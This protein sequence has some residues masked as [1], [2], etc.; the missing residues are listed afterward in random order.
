MNRKI[1]GIAVIAVVIVGGVFGVRGLFQSKTLKSVNELSETH[2]GGA[3]LKEVARDKSDNIYSSS[4]ITKIEG[5]GKFNRKLTVYGLTLMAH[6]SVSDEFLLKIN[7][8]MISMF[9]K[10][11]GLNTKLQEDILQNLYQYK[12][13]LPVVSS[14]SDL[15]DEKIASKMRK[16]YSLCDIIM[17]TDKNQVNEVVEH[18]LH[19]I[20]D[21]G[22]HHGMTDEWGLKKDSLVEKQMQLAINE[23]YYLVENYKGYPESIKNRILIQEYAYWVISS[24]WNLQEP[25][26]VGDQ[27]WRLNNSK[28]LSEKQGEMVELIRGTVDKIMVAPYKTILDSF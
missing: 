18:L 14:E 22:F 23:K 15:S 16:E 7:D 3:V 20:T 28:L 4:G 19:A 13:M 12:A 26:G 25:Y 8:T 27:E 2:I 11:E 24:S 1:I 5:Y 9:P 6:E 17:K 10:G 21:V